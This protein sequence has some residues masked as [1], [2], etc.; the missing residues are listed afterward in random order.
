MSGR[1]P[2]SASAR[3]KSPGRVSL[4]CARRPA[5]PPPRCRPPAPPRHRRRRRR[6][7]RGGRRGFRDSGSPAGSARAVKPSRSAMAGDA[8][9]L[10]AATAHRS[11]AA[12]ARRRDGVQRRAARRG[13]GLGRHQRAGGV[14]DQHVA[15]RS[16]ASSASSPARTDAARSAPP[17][18]QRTPGKAAARPASSG[19]S[20][21]DQRGPRQRGPE[22]RPAHASTTG[23]PAKHLPLLRLA[24]AHAKTASGGDDDDGGVQRRLS[25]G[26]SLGAAGWP[27]NAAACRQL[28]AHNS[29]NLDRR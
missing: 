16:S 14:V 1:P 8:V 21:S 22:C 11:A 3:A 12:P 9:A 20:T 26:N 27:C 15:Q 28:V 7:G 6:D 25:S 13:S 4:G 24:P 10:A 19:G 17:A 23:R 29:G 18:T 2:T 5:P